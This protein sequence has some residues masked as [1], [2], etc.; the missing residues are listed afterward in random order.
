MADINMQVWF[1]LKVFM[2]FETRRIFA[3][4]FYEMDAPL[5][6]VCHDWPCRHLDYNYEDTQTDD[7]PSY[8]HYG[9]NNYLNDIDP[10]FKSEN[11]SIKEENSSIK[12]C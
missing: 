6:S 8:H 7:L 2:N 11:V 3:T 12:G 10:L 9:E 4:S 5:S 1:C